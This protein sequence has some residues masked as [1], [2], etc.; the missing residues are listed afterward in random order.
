MIIGVLLGAAADVAKGL[1]PKG[2]PVKVVDAIAGRGIQALIDDSVK[3]RG[4]LLPSQAVGVKLGELIKRVVPKGRFERSVE[5]GI[6]DALV[7][8]AAEIEGPLR[9]REKPDPTS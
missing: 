2:K 1:L 7:A 4:P 9:T 6:A 5:L 3:K 8:A